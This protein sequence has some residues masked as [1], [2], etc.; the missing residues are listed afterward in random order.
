M[1]KIVLCLFLLILFF[2]VIDNVWASVDSA[3]SY[4]LMDLD[5]GRVY[6]AKNKD[7]P[8]LIA[9]ITNIMTT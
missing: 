9:S 7:K 2:G 8:M 6:G 3:Y 5:S 1:R 4:V